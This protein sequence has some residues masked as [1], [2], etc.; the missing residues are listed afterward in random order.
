MDKKKGMRPPSAPPFYT[1]FQKLI[2]ESDL[3]TC[4]PPRPSTASDKTKTNLVNRPGLSNFTDLSYQAPCMPLPPATAAT[5]VLQR[6]INSDSLLRIFNETNAFRNNEIIVMSEVGDLQGFISAIQNGLNLVTCRGLLG[7]TALHHACN[8]GHVAIVSEILK[9]QLYVINISN[10]TGESALH[11]AVY[12]GNMNITEQ[13]LDHGANVDA[14]NDYGETPLFYAARRNMPA[15][16]KLLLQRG[17]SAGIIDRFGE[18]AADHCTSAHTL[19][20]FEASKIDQSGML[21]LNELLLVFKFLDTRDICRCA[22]VAGKWH[23]VSETESIWANLGVRRYVLRNFLLQI[24]Q[25]NEFGV[26]THAILNTF[27]TDGRCPYS[28]HW[29]LNLQLLQPFVHAIYRNLIRLGKVLL[30]R[31]GNLLPQYLVLGI[32]IKGQWCRKIKLN[33]D[34]NV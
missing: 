20:A 31:R 1:P 21:P 30:T 13:L 24:L 3:I 23:R 19:Q 10:D 2:D 8:R 7:Y 4:L 32:P 28:G 15:L 12:A 25:K 16:I 27:N 26:F 34:D 18:I 5:A 22:M 11:L 14:K 17:S 33:V 9:A 6:E 29:D